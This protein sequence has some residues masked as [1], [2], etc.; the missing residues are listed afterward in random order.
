MSI[1]RF[2]GVIGVLTAVCSLGANAA[3]FDITVDGT[4]SVFLAGYTATPPSAAHVVHVRHGPTPGS[5]P[6]G[7]FETL[8]PMLAVAGGDVIRVADPAV[9]GVNFFLGFGPPFFGP[10]GGSTSGSALGSFGGI[11]G[12]TGPPGP[13]AGVFLGAGDPTGGSAPPVLDFGLIG[14]DFLSLAPDI[15]QVF[16]IG[17]GVTSGGDFQTFI[18]P[19]GATRLYLGIPDGFGFTGPPGA[20]D[21]NDGA[22]RVRIGVN[23]IPTVDAP[24]T[25]ALAA[26][27]VT[28]IVGWRRRAGTIDTR[29]A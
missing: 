23:Q 2:A 6:E 24:A 21:D 25:L 14:L 15:G 9:G 28:A 22:Y 1:K 8:P 3:I 17:D 18:A 10:G 11:S 26:L 13:L 7:L 29:K 19:T 5:T 20:Y 27:G 4:D 12:Y 16:Y